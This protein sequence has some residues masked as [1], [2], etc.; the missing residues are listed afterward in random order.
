[1]KTKSTGNDEFA[2]VPQDG[3]DVDD[4]PMDFARYTMLPMHVL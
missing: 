3:D 2:D 1:M 4:E